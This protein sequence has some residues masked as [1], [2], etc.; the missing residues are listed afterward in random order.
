[1]KRNTALLLSSLAVLAVNTAYSEELLTCPQSMELNRDS[2][3]HWWST[4]ATHDP[5][6]QDSNAMVNHKWYSTSP[7][8]AEKLGKFV[9]AQYSG[10][11]EGHIICLYLSDSSTHMQSF[12]VSVHF[13]GL[14]VAPKQGEWKQ[15]PTHG[16][17]KNCVSSDPLQCPYLM[18]QS[19]DV[20][21]P[22]EFLRKLA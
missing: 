15:D 6:S 2:Q 3:Q 7:S 12:P 21:D 4:K 19:D 10:T 18:Y 16:G 17:I 11:A 22:Y 13:E 1:M 14:V 5:H 8:L 9:G 20:S